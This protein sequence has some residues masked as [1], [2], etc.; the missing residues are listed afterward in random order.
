MC[1]PVGTAFKSI[2]VCSLRRIQKNFFVQI[3]H[4]VRCI[5]QRSLV[6]PS[7]VWKT[8]LVIDRLRWGILNAFLSKSAAV[9]VNSRAVRESRAYKQNCKQPFVQQEITAIFYVKDSFPSLLAIW[10]CAITY[11][12]SSVVMH[13]ME[14]SLVSGFVLVNEGG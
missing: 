3:F 8:P 5:S 11:P 12:I 4:T 1:Q 7:V 10:V 14:S 13:F 9:P 6:A 2:T